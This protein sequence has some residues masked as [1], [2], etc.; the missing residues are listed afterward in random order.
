M[1]FEI[2]KKANIIYNS[3]LE[4]EK[5]LD[6]LKTERYEIEI[7]IPTDIDAH[8]LLVNTIALKIAALKLELLTLG[9]KFEGKDESKGE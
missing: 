1:D 4:H 6:F 7:G 8:D 2:F 5:V 3:I 9:I